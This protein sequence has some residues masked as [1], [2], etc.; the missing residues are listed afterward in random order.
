MVI[1]ASAAAEHYDEY[2]RRVV[3]PAVTARPT[4]LSSRFEKEANS[5]P[6]YKDGPAAARTP[7]I[8]EAMASPT[9]FFLFRERVYAYFTAR[10]QQSAQAS[11]LMESRSSSKQREKKV[12]TNGADREVE[13]GSEGK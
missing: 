1:I 11:A 6:Y 7:L 5:T 2:V 3:A 10:T 4:V 13:R 9:F 8:S 12:Q